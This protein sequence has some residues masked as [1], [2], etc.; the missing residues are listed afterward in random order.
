MTRY[1]GRTVKLGVLH[2]FAGPSW[3]MCCV[4]RPHQEV[5]A[6]QLLP[7]QGDPADKVGLHGVE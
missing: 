7:H 6:R 4:R 2:I 5:T 1:T 3:R